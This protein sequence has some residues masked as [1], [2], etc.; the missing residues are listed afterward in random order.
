MHMLYLQRGE[1]LIFMYARFALEAMQ[2]AT[3]QNI[4]YS[5]NNNVRVIATDG[6]RYLT[7]FHFAAKQ[8]AK[9]P[10]CC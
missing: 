5:T 7:E 6:G 10:E 3:V 8:Q 1:F 2:E 9:P 4:L